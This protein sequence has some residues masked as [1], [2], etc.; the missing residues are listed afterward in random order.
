MAGRD[1]RLGWMSLSL[2]VVGAVAIL[3]GLGT[4]LIRYKTYSASSSSMEP[5]LKRGTH[6][7]ADLWAYQDAPPKRGDVIVFYNKKDNLEFVK[8]VMGLPGE[9][10]QMRRGV[11][12]INDTP[13]QQKP[14]PNYQIENFHGEKT[15]V[16]RSIEVLASGRCHQILNVDDNG[17]VDNTL[18]F[19]I[20]PGNY[21][22]LGDN[23]DNSIDSRILPSVGYVPRSRIIGRVVVADVK[24]C[25]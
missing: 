14:S 19:E 21:F 1:V 13:I 24:P 10:I 18:E 6:F 17:R 22:V 8:R 5:T 25:T 11:V 23:R 4:Y 2:I 15:E 9:T 3:A 16:S 20:P 12:H 7:F